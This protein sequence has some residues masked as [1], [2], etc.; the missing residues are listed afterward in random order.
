MK[1]VAWAVLM[2]IVLITGSAFAEDYAFD[3][4]EE[5]KRVGASTFVSTS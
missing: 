1:R 2:G 4:G 3:F 5:V